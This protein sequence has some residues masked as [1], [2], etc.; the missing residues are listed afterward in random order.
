MKAVVSAKGF[1]EFT[2]ITIYN[3][4]ATSAMARALR[5]TVRAKRSRRSHVFGWVV[6]AAGL[7]LSLP[8]GE[9]SFQLSASTVVTWLS[10]L[11]V[12]SALLWEDR[13]NG[14]FAFK[15]KVP[16]L[17]T[18]TTTFTAEGYHSVTEVGISDF[19][20][21]NISAL[22]ETKEYFVLI[23]GKNHA[24]VYAKNGITGGSVEEFRAFIQEV[25]GKKI[26]KV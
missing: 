13:M 18:S 12:L 21:A 1:M 9:E 6:I 20:Y 22:A 7:Y 5:K 25:T 11:V 26:A 3:Q 10:V 19:F 24:Q 23:L 17:N 14:Y 8:L 15:R 2:F 16:G 4:K